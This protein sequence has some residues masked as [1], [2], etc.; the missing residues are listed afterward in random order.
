MLC[1]ESLAEATGVRKVYYLG[2]YT[3]GR[4]TVQWGE[5]KQLPESGHLGLA[6]SHIGSELCLAPTWA[7]S[8]PGPSSLLAEMQTQKGSSPLLSAYVIPGLPP[9]CIPRLSS[10]NVSSPRHL[11]M[12][13]GVSLPIHWMSFLKPNQVPSS[14]WLKD[15]LDPSPTCVIR[16]SAHC[17]SISCCPH[18]P[19]SSLYGG[20]YLAGGSFQDPSQALQHRLTVLPP[21]TSFSLLLLPPPPHTHW[22]YHSPYYLIS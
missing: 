18:S 6:K 21:M 20:D 4:W 5:S 15:N 16:S 14:H 9:P 17:P 3:L 10:L 8:V 1:V 12:H 11:I 2:Q 19:A 7:L 13:N 22:L